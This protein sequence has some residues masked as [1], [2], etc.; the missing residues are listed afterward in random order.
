MSTITKSSLREKSVKNNFL[1]AMADQEFANL[2]KSLNVSDDELMKNTSKLEDTI[3]ELK[4]CRKCPGLAAC[5]NK[6]LGCVNFPKNYH[7]H[8][9]FSYVACKYQ[10]EFINK[11]NNKNT[12]EKIIAEAQMKDIDLT[13]KNR[14]KLVKWID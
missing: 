3:A 11:E 7:N 10:K 9:I 8:L 4:K 1:K 13:D 6:E 5:Q 2:A 12:E 14:V